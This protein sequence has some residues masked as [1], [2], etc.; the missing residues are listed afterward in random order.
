MPT[1]QQITDTHHRWPACLFTATAAAAA[2]NDGP[3]PPGSF[4]FVSTCVR[5][6]EACVWD[7]GSQTKTPRQDA[8]WRGTWGLSSS[9]QWCLDGGGG[10]GTPAAAPPGWP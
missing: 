9:E 1:P 4:S 5:Q 8:E 2:N 7:N 10:G 6:M 3:S